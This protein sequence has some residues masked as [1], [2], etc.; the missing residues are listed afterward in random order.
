MSRSNGRLESEVIANYIDGFS[1]SKHKMEEAFRSGGFLDKPPAKSPTHSREANAPVLKRE[2]I[3]LIV[4]EFEVSRSQAE[5]I[6]AAN[7]ADLG[8]ALRAL[9]ATPQ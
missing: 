5:K 4:H 8:K 6:L 1:Y 7:D 2:D 9:V 3:D